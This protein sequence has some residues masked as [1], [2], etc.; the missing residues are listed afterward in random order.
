MR[1]QYFCCHHFLN[2]L[3]FFWTCIQENMMFI[4]D[5]AFL[6]AFKLLTVY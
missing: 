2:E 3:N 6:E 5:E 1:S 4:S